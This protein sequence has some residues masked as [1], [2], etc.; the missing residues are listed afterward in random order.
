MARRGRTAGKRT[1]KRASTAPAKRSG[2]LK[3]SGGRKT[4]VGHPQHTGQDNG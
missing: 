3:S 4:A 2:P 1:T